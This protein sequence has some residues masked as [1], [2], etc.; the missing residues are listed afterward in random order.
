[1]ILQLNADKI[2]NVHE[3]FGK[4]LKD[5]ISKRLQRFNEHISTLEI[6]ITDE[7]GIKIGPKEIK[8]KMEAH[9]KGM[10]SIVVTESANTL[11]QSFYGAVDKL[12]DSLDS[13]IGR[14]RDHEQHVTK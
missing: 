4:Q 2:L 14:A 11:E 9:L 6:H 3:A 12:K 13:I 8:C 10:Q 7:N 1:M 5:S